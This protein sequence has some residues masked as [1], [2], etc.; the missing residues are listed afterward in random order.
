MEKGNSIPCGTNS[1]KREP[2]AHELMCTIDRVAALAEKVAARVADGLHAVCLP[3][4][5]SPEC[6]K[7][8]PE[9]EY[10]PLLSDMRSRIYA[11]E[12][13]LR[14]ISNVMDRCEV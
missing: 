6:E 13:S 9:R 2:A 14:W 11:I 4:R 5:P 8:A 1:A 10:P 7:E 12:R 3:E